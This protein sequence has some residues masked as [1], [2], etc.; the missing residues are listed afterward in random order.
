MTLCTIHTLVKTHFIVKINTQI[1]PEQFTVKANPGLFKG[2]G[3]K[4]LRNTFQRHPPEEFLSEDSAG[5]FALR[6]FRLHSSLPLCSLLLTNC[7]GSH[8]VRLLIDD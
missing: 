6:I 2:E 8:S 1:I 5:G 7:E 4:K 3:Q